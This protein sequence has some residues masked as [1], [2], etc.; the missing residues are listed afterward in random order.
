M[1]I[2]D[3]TFTLKKLLNNPEFVKNRDWKYQRFDANETIIRKGDNTDD[4]YM[5]VRGTVRVVGRVEVDGS[6]KMRPGVAK[7][8]V[9]DIFG[10]MA[11]FDNDP[12]SI[13]VIANNECELVMVQKQA[14]LVFM[15]NNPRAG[16]AIIKELFCLL[17]GRLRKIDNMLM[18]VFS[19]GT[20]SYRFDKHLPDS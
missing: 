12:R 9:G 8:G 20:K 17:T 15:E 3:E 10:E 13:T 5:I 1:E 7:L 11:L 14:L 19:W 2:S 6:C 4:I 16:Y 18:D